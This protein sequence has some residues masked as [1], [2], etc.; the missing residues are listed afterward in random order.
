M[1]IYIYTHNSHID[2]P[3]IHET[4]PTHFHRNCPKWVSPTRSA[5]LLTW[6]TWMPRPFH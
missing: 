4:N 2:N 6:I 1:Y 3:K 5:M